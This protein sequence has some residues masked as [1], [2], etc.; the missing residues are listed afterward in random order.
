[1]II[2]VWFLSLNSNKSLL[3]F[4]FC[5]DFAYFL[6]SP[7]SPSN[8]FEYSSTSFSSFLYIWSRLCMISRIQRQFLERLVRARTVFYKQVHTPFLIVFSA[9][10]TNSLFFPYFC[11]IL[12]Q[13]SFYLTLFL[14][15]YTLVPTSFSSVLLYFI[16]IFKALILL[17]HT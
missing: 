1:M 10:L 14:S 8:A 15:S 9:I 11:L 13:V 16:Q 3:F 2:D 5:S 7:G 4:F 6:F 12:L 17:V